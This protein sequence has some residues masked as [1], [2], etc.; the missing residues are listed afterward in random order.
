M[1]EHWISELE[2]FTAEDRMILN[3]TKNINSKA[4]N[5]I[6]L[7]TDLQL[8]AELGKTL[9][10]RNRELENELKQH[11]STIDDQ[12][13]EIEVNILLT[14]IFFWNLIMVLS[15]ST[16]PSKEQDRSGGSQSS[17]PEFLRKT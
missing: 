9:L 6:S 2:K 3:I 14:I 7:F 8:A 12:A 10:E 11:Q 1:F 4:N 15:F 16:V 13:Q 17:P 5:Q